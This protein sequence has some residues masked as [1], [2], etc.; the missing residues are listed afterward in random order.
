MG[1]WRRQCLK[2]KLAK[3]S[4]SSILTWSICSNWSLFPF[5]ADGSF[6]GGLIGD[7]LILCLIFSPVPHFFSRA[8]QLSWLR[9]LYLLFSVGTLSVVS[10]SRARTRT[11][12][13]SSTREVTTSLST[14]S[15]SSTAVKLPSSSTILLSTLSFPVVNQTFWK[16]WS[17][18]HNLWVCSGISLR[19]E[20]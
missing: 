3:S 4:T 2:R 19:V 15:R 16:L 5:V 10:L 20:V 13:I 7:I 14:S 6:R 8:M 1:A 17:L 11:P 18:C 12:F 9:S